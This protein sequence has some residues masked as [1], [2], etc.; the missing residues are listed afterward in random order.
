MFAR[1]R[2]LL[3]IAASAVAMPVAAQAPATTTTAFDGNLWGSVLGGI[4][5]HAGRRHAA[6]AGKG[7]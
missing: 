4:A 5:I 6:G 3:T 2:I 1:A 7:L